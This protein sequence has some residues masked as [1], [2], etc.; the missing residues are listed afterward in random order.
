MR[1]SN[2]DLFTGGSLSISS[3]HTI[4]FTLNF[5]LTT[6]PRVGT[7][8]VTWG[9]C[10]SLM[11]LR[12]TAPLGTGPRGIV[13]EEQGPGPVLSGPWCGDADVP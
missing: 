2:C 6:F 4:S 13:L 11:P 3:T 1:V 10:G 7:R 9:L 12:E 5:A 8:V